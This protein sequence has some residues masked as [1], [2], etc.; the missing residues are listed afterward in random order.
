M[1]FANEQPAVTALLHTNAPYTRLYL[2][3]FPLLLYEK[4]LDLLRNFCDLIGLIKTVIAISG[5]HFNIIF[6]TCLFLFLLGDR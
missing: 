5:I 1:G 6:F 2:K 4:A 3:L